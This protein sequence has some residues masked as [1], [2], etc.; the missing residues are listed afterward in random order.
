MNT[1]AQVA[2]ALSLR[3]YQIDA[4]A[5]TRRR[6]A[7]VRSV[8][9]NAPTGAGKTIL[10]CQIIRLAVEKQRR[11][12]FLAHR[13]ELIDQCA[14]KL[15]EAGVLHHGVILAGH[16]KARAP[17]APVQVASIQTLIRRELPPADLVMI[18]ECITGD[19][20]ILTDKGAI[21]IKDIRIGIRAMS[22]NNGNVIYSE[23]TDVWMSGEKD[24]L[25]IAVETGETIRCTENHLLMTKEGW[26][27][28]KDIMPSSQ[29]LL[30]NA[31]AEPFCKK[32]SGDGSRF[33][34]QVTKESPA[35]E[36]EINGQWFSMKS[37]LALLFAGAGAGKKRA[38]NPAIRLTSSS[39]TKEA[40]LTTNTCKGM[41]AGL[42]RGTPRL[43]IQSAKQF[44]EHFLETQ[45]S[46]IRTKQ[47]ERLASVLTTAVPKPHGQSTKQTS[48]KDWAGNPQEGKTKDLGQLLSQERQGVFL[49]LRRFISYASRMARKLLVENG[50]S[51]LE[52]SAWLGG[53]AMTV[54]AAGAAS[55]CILKDTHWQRTKLFASGLGIDMV[56]QVSAQESADISGSICL[57][58]LNEKSCQ[59]SSNISQSVCNTS[60][61]QVAHVRRLPQ[62]E[63]VY[64]ITVAETH[65]FFANGILTHNCHRAMAKS[66]LNLLAN[67]PAAKIIGLTATP[68][69][70]DGK[71][72]GDLFDDMVVVSTIPN[73]IAEG[74]LV[75]P[76][77]YGAPSGGPDL[78][79]VKKSG[80]DYREDQLQAAM[81][82]TE[83]TGELLTNWQRL[84][85]NQKTIV[86]ASGID[87]SQHIVN[88]FRDAG[89]SAAHLD[90][91]TP[92]PLRQQ[93]IRDWQSGAL[94]VVSNCAVL[95]E[96]FD[97]PSLECCV[98]ARPTQSVAMYL[99]QVG[100]V[101]RPAPGKAGAMVL[102]H[103]GCF[104]AHGLPHDHREWTLEGETERRKRKKA[105]PKH[106]RV[107]S[108]AHEADESRWLLDSQPHLH[109]HK[110]L[111]RA[112]AVLIAGTGLV[113]CPGCSMSDCLICAAPFNAG[114]E[115]PQCT[116]CGALYTAE[117]KEQPGDG[118]RALPLESSDLL[119]RWTES[120]ANARLKIKNEFAKLINQAREK[121][122]KRGWAFHQ[123]KEKY[124]D[125]A[126]D[127][128]PRHTG[129]WWR[130]T[131]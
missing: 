44:L 2:P 110:A 79:R 73:L 77:C 9:I 111:E 63:S 5:E 8:L 75:E 123:L 125:A 27:K 48:L 6:M 50:L 120:P 31:G 103:A 129:D 29:L 92:L 14:A 39:D 118:E 94:Q 86:F 18:D 131:A 102:D 67:Y 91:A 26:T 57:Q 87:H 15:D 16:A 71:G 117:E 24:V 33:S 36:Q 97:F 122:Y 41:A 53:S 90:G 56:R 1:P 81:D 121:G 40:A 47:A 70:L 112:K 124:G 76:D 34:F 105:P 61:H 106:C 93:I 128:L 11:V 96:G 65:C 109:G 19:S 4:I 37:K 101:M 69:R 7:R 23:I 74:F 82:T 64:D 107:C 28:A 58:T 52:K 114:S 89:V 3:P 10:G 22:Y 62:K 12:L 45:A 21:P 115:A 20:L 13:R 59:S 113:V 49:I 126:L 99:Q 46:F 127:A 95:T 54:Q 42:Y 108:L 60:W 85:A 32:T 78:S 88:R 51:R 17:H 100:R 119:E 30:A 83:L 35:Q 80:G 66:Y 68:E 98:L 38:R 116:N 84:A 72:L 104:N 25:E 55:I 130:Q 43:T